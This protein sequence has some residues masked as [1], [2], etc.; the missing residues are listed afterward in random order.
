MKEFGFGRR[1]ME[2]RIC[3]EVAEFVKQARLFGGQPFNPNDVLPMCVVNII[4]G[5]MLGRRYPFG[6]PALQKTAAA[7]HDVLSN[8]VMEL[9]LWPI[10]RFVPP[11]KGRLQTVLT[12]YATY[13]KLV[14]E[15]VILLTYLKFSALPVRIGM[16]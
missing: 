9:E 12:A 16:N 4:I 2:S 7:I 1:I 10:L 3:V 11:F 5:I 15:E 8:Y 13:M 14:Q 6:H